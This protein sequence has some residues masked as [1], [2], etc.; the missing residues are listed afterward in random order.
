MGDG[1]VPIY[2]G[3]AIPKGGRK[4]ASTTATPESVALFSRLSEH[5]KSINSVGSLE[6]DDF[7][8]RCLAVDDIWISLGES[9]LIDRFQ[10]VWNVVV[11]G[12]GNHDPGNGRYGGKRPLWDELHPGR[13]WAAR[14][15]PPK[16]TA[17]E[18]GSAVRAYLVAQF[19]N[20]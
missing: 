16:K 13:A 1:S 12:F 5:A 2:V 20:P 9:L 18:I 8:C 4:G 7:T 19:A 10:P 3:K 6:L 14:C 11:E 17:A 15:A